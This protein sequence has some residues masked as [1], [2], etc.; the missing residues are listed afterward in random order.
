VVDR[1]T[2]VDPDADL[3]AR[4]GHQEVE[5]KLHRTE[6]LFQMELR[7]VHLAESIFQMNH[8]LFPSER[9]CV[10]VTDEAVI[11]TEI[12]V[13]S[14]KHPGHARG[15]GGWPLPDVETQRDTR[16]RARVSSRSSSRLPPGQGLLKSNAFARGVAFPSAPVSG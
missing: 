9:Q 10:V 7:V 5:H 4:K 11:S 16:Q 3:P 2:S 12:D 14:M 15:D 8:G 6:R 1:T 13:D